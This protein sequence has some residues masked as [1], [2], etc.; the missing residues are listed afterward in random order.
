MWDP[1]HLKL[2][3][4][5]WPLTRISGLFTPENIVKGSHAGA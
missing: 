1:D 3:R 2:Y 4:P 5:A